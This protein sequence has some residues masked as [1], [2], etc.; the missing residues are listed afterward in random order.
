MGCFPFFVEIGGAPGLVVGGGEVAVRKIEKLLPFAPRL[1]AVALDFTPEIERMARQYVPEETGGALEQLSAAD[2]DFTLELERVARRYGSEE[3]G[4]APEK[5]AAADSDFTPEPERRAASRGTLRLLRAPFDDELV[6]GQRFVIAATN[7]RALNARIA[8]LC[9]AQGILVNVVD[10]PALC[11]F[12]FPALAKRG[13]LTVGVSTDG[14]SPA[15]AQW[16]RDQTAALL[17]ERMEEIMDCLAQWRIRAAAALPGEQAERRRAFH[18][19]LFAACMERGGVLPEDETE[20]LLQNMA[21]SDCAAALPS[22]V[23]YLVGAGCGRADLITVRGLRLLRRCGAVVYDDLIDKALLEELPVGAQRFFM[24]KREGKR[25]APQE[26]ICALL[27]RLARQGKT[28]VRLKGG[29]PY[30]FGRGA[31]EAQALTAAG[32]RWESVPGV[33]AAIAIPEEAGIPV[34]C[35]GLS[36]SVHIV[37]AHT[38]GTGDGLPED[39]EQL[40]K[41]HGTLVFLMGLNRLERIAARLRAAGMD[42]RTPAAVLSGGCAPHPA[43]VRGTLGD[44]AQ[45]TRRAGVQPPAVIVVGQTAALKLR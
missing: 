14:A 24:G 38:A 29:D 11:T 13:M 23:V 36:R 17:P 5:L 39:L 25:S 43:A 15:A 19:A 35:R 45:R 10:D 44:I 27:V 21:V 40:A 4:G 9:G 22:G 28:V 34:T 41:L 3:T 2:S 31:E 1:T 6:Q 30:V 42:E 12:L 33:S 32:V 37:T 8:A 7:D 16:V 18:K 20:A 26:E